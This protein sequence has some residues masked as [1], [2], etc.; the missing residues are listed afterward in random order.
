MPHDE[1]LASAYYGLVLAARRYQPELGGLWDAFAFQWA[2]QTIREDFRRRY[3]FKIGLRANGK[4][5]LRPKGRI[6]KHRLQSRERNPA[7]TAE[8][9]DDMD[10]A[11][12]LSRDLPKR[13]R[14]VISLTLDGLEV[15]QIAA[16]LGIKIRAVYLHR[17]L[18]VEG[19]RKRL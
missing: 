18:G 15:E 7:E 3:V 11:W 6:E 2:F 1:C 4:W 10:C 13:Q 9:R 12:R 14:Q 19:V 8:R 5:G 17:Q 16:R